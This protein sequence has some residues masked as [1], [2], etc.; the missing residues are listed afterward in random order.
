MSKGKFSFVLPNLGAHM[1]MTANPPV[2][3]VR[4]S[5]KEDS[6]LQPAEQ[7]RGKVIN[8]ERPKLTDLPQAMRC[9]GWE[10]APKLM[11]KWFAGNPY[12]LME[13]DRTIYNLDPR[14]IPLE[15]VDESIVTLAWAEKFA[16]YHKAREELLKKWGAKTTEQ[17]I[18]N[19]VEKANLSE[20]QPILATLA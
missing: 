3:P 11:E 14:Q 18:R 17:S 9:M 13:A 6:K 20:A 2:S 1:P 7:T 4:L 16:L 5:L 8:F 12:E 10:V 19:I 15:R